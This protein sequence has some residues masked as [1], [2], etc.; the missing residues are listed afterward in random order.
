M[1]GN[2]FYKAMID[3]FIAHFHFNCVHLEY[4]ADI[5]TYCGI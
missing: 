1:C 2:S 3:D 5:N 4:L